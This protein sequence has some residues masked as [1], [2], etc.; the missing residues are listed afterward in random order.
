MLNTDQFRSE[1]NGKI[2]SI[3]FDDTIFDEHEKPYP[4]VG[5][6]F[7]NSRVVINKWW[8]RG[9][10][11]IINTCRTNIDDT[12]G[13]LYAEAALAAEQI[14]YD[15]INENCPDLIVKY[16]G[17]CRK[18]SADL[19]ID[20]K[21]LG[22]LPLLYTGDPDWLAIDSLIENY[23]EN[24]IEVPTEEQPPVDT[25]KMVLDKWY[26]DWEK[27]VAAN[28]LPKTLFYTNNPN[29]HIDFDFGTTSDSADT[30]AFAINALNKI[31]GISA[32]EV[33]V[34]TESPVTITPGKDNMTI[35]WTGPGKATFNPDGS[36]TI[37][38][39]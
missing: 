31:D 19:Y 12:P 37:T 18:I 15:H 27:E 17:D 2:I 24:R 33:E 26:S 39:I 13:Q 11:I 3:D 20:N 29:P 5:R 4:E 8:I 34:D 30:F 28:G 1:R 36:I 22:G 10:T 6:R 14:K 16:N 35:S 9:Y 23:F 38:K 25:D 32:K 7:A 21:C